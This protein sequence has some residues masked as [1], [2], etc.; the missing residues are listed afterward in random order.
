MPARRLSWG[1]TGGPARCGF[2]PASTWRERGPATCP[3]QIPGSACRPTTPAAHR[4]LDTH[5]TLR[6]A[7]WNLRDPGPMA[8]GGAGMAAQ[9][10]SH[11]WAIPAATVC[12]LTLG[13][14]V[15]VAQS[16]SAGGQ[17]V[18]E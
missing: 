10:R 18:V 11:L 6:A 14:G 13:A 17:Q 12:A 5:E 7:P 15:V 16:P 4:L 2:L 1:A 3:R 9:S 8:D